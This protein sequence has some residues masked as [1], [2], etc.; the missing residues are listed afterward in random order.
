MAEEIKQK[1]V[2]PNIILRN[3][4]RII[5][6]LTGIVAVV[7]LV[8]G[9]GEYGFWNEYKGPK[10]GFFPTIIATMQ[11]A[12]SVLAFIQGNKD[13]RPSLPSKNWLAAIG[14]LSMVLGSYIIGMEPAILVFLLV[15]LRAYE[16]CSWKIV[17]LTS[18]VMMTIVIGAFDLW[19]GIDFPKGFFWMILG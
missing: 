16:K 5:P 3:L 13:K 18:A 11:L 17:I 6:A 19:L 9:L 15:W 1:G 7:F 12:M 8:K 4:S 10:S 14:M 2:A